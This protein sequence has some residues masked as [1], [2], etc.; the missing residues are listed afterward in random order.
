MGLSFTDEELEKY[1]YVKPE[2]VPELVEYVKSRRS[3]LKGFVPDRGNIQ[4]ISKPQRM[5]HI[6]NY[7]GT[8]GKMQVSTTMAFVRLLRSLMKSED[9]V[10]RIV[11]IIP[12]EARTFGMDPLFSNFGIYPRRPIV[13]SS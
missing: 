9:G 1:P 5:Q 11:P 7:E 12:D 4:S 13:Y 10:P 6:P 2:D 8:K 3:E